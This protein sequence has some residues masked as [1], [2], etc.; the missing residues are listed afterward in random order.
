M[1]CCATFA[2]SAWCITEFQ[3][4]LCRIVYCCRQGKEGQTGETEVSIFALSNR[5]LLQS[6]KNDYH[7]VLRVSIFALSNRVLLLCG[8]ST[9]GNRPNV[10]IFALSNRV[11]LRFRQANHQPAVECFNIRSVESCTAAFASRA[12]QSSIASVSIFALSNRVL[13]QVM[14]ITG[15]HLRF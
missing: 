1:Y 7:E 12:R 5:V 3:Y 2:L 11:L 14:K 10:S 13:L 8:D 9:T 4:S 15:A 6:R